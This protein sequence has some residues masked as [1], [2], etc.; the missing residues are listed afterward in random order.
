MVHRCCFMLAARCSTGN[1]ADLWAGGRKHQPRRQWQHEPPASF[2]SL[3]SHGYVEPVAI[4][5][6]RNI[7]LTAYAVGD[8]H[9]LYVTVI[10][11]T[12]SSTHDVTDAIVTVRAKDLKTASAAYMILTDGQP[13]NAALMTATL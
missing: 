7:N 11:K 1:S 13:G 2:R 3:G 6:P 4:S 8:A 9:D 5:N 12:H 10:N